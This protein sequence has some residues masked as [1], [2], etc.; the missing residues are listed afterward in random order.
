MFQHVI[1]SRCFTPSLTSWHFF[2]ST[3]TIKPGMRAV[4]YL[5]RTNFASASRLSEKI[6]CFAYFWNRTIVF[7]ISVVLYNFKQR[8]NPPEQ[9]H[10]YSQWGYQHIKLRWTASL[11]K[12]YLWGHYIGIFVNKMFFSNQ[13]NNKYFH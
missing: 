10:E 12:Q 11:N 1:L 7:N 13:I 8:R 6:F 4:V 5:W 9:E 2:R 3:R